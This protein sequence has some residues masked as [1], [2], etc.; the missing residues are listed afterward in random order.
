MGR[1]LSH[2]PICR[3]CGIVQRHWFMIHLSEH[4]HIC[5][6]CWTNSTISQKRIWRHNA[7]KKFNKT[8]R[9]NRL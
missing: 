8:I 6:G 2:T 4:F 1:A 7:N 9:M 5:L 3:S